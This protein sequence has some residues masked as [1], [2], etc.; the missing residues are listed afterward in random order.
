[1]TRKEY[2]E[3]QKLKQQEQ[4]ES[5]PENINI[6]DLEAMLKE[7]KKGI[8]KVDKIY[9][10]YEEKGHLFDYDLDYNRF[11]GDITNLLK[12]YKKEEN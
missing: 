11:L 7:A 2:E 12:I 4:Q 10:N 3:R 8:A 9:V 1:M 5:E 6:N